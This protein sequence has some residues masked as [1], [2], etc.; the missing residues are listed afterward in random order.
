MDQVSAMFEHVN[1]IHGFTHL[2][3]DRM[4]AIKK[5]MSPLI[6]RTYPPAEH[7]NAIHGLTSGAL[8]PDSLNP[9]LH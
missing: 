7:V 5:R 4:N 2:P 3:A 6:E 1:L 9:W 8:T